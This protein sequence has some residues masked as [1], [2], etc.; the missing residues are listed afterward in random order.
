MITKEEFE[1]RKRQ[2]AEFNRFKRSEV[3]PVYNPEQVL[4]FISTILEWAP[5]DVRTQECD[6]ERLGVQRMR[7]LLGALPQ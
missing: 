2:W 6:P 3:R 1:L 4:D 7:R 5:Q